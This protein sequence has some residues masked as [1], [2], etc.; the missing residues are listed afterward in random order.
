MV[1]F[2]LSLH[3]HDERNF[4]VLQYWTTI[5]LNLLKYSFKSSFSL[6]VVEGLSVFLSVDTVAQQERRRRRIRW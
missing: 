4:A 3:I 6:L 5:L 2:D 1:F